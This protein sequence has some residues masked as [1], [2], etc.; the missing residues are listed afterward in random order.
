MKVTVRTRSR[1]RLSGKQ[2]NAIVFRR[3]R[4]YDKLNFSESFAMFMGR[5][6]IVEFGLKKLLMDK[7]GLEEEKI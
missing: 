5:A 6:Q 4:K 7:Y 3:L 1:K 2:V